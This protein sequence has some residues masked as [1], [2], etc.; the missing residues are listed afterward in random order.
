MHITK[1]KSINLDKWPK[2]VANLFTKISKIS[3]IINYSIYYITFFLLDNKIANDY[4]E[5]KLKD[6]DFQKLQNDDYR[7]FDFIKDKYERK[8]YAKKGKDP[9]TLIYEG[10]DPEESEKKEKV[11]DSDD[12][13]EK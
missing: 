1:I 5:H 4:W 8:R 10:K 11:R 6:M 13:D 7:L 2:G 3:F 12:S 9:M